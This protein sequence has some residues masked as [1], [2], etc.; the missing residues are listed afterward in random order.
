MIRPGIALVLTGIWLGALTLA[1]PQD[2]TPDLAGVYLVDGVNPDGTTYTAA[3]ELR[4]HDETWALTWAFAPSGGQGIG[5]GLLNGSV[6]SVIF[7]VET[8]VGLVAFQRD[9]QGRWVGRWTMPGG[10]GV[11]TETLTKTAA[12]SLEDVRGPRRGV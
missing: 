5:I 8:G 6:L 9:A 4:Q 10:A 7:Q 12:R 11:G 2:A 3:V 1:A